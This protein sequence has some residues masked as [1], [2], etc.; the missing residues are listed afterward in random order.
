MICSPVASTFGN[1]KWSKSR[2]EIDS[3]FKL[4]ELKE[5]EG[6]IDAE[7]STYTLNADK[8]YFINRVKIYEQFCKEHFATYWLHFIPKNLMSYH[9]LQSLPAIIEL[10]DKKD[11]LA[12]PFSIANLTEHERMEEKSFLPKLHFRNLLNNIVFELL[13]AHPV[14]EHF[15]SSAIRRTEPAIQNIDAHYIRTI[16]LDILAQICCMSPNHFHKLFKHTLN[17]T[18]ANYQ[19]ILKMNA[20]LQMLDTTENP[21]KS[22]AVDLGFV[23]NAHFTKTFKPHFVLSPKVYRAS[24]LENADPFNN[25][26]T[27]QTSKFFCWR[28][29]FPSYRR[30]T[31]LFIKV[32]TDKV[33][34]FVF[35][36][37][38]RFRNTFLTYLSQL[39]HSI[40][41]FLQL[42]SS[43]PICEKGFSHQIKHNNH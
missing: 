20:A 13:V 31:I 43:L 2:T 5:G 26:H 7:A 33:Y 37:H 24:K 23:D 35:S 29:R 16:K 28:K 42:K 19:A 15:T 11:S 9:K 14:Q 10:T 1:S 32:R 30:K 22:I 18:P 27:Q 41:L 40:I 25:E 3:C 36:T 21:I 6:S 12:T 39:S 4:Y 38:K 17:I 8:L 34:T